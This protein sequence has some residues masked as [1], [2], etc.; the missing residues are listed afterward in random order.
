MYN[1][2]QKPLHECYPT[3]KAK[4]TQEVGVAWARVILSTLRRASARSPRETLKS[5]SSRAG[6]LVRTR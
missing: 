2:I 3:S 1:R 6:N 5:E 4:A